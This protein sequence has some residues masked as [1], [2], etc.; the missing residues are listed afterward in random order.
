MDEKGGKN[1]EFVIEL[2][3]ENKGKIKYVKY[4]YVPLDVDGII[5]WNLIRVG[6]HKIIANDNH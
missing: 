4:I 6:I 1:S 2:E 3:G 5:I